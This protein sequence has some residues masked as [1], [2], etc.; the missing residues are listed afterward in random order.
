MAITNITQSNFRYG[1]REY[2]GKTVVDAGATPEA[3]LLANQGDY[4]VDAGTPVT[5]GLEILA[6]VSTAAIDRKCAVATLVAGATT[7]A[8]AI[9][10]PTLVDEDVIVSIGNGKDVRGGQSY[11]LSIT[12]SLYAGALSLRNLYLGSMTPIPVTPVVA[13]G[14][15]TYTAQ[16]APIDTTGNL[17]INWALGFDGKGVGSATI[18]TISLVQVV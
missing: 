17:P 2:P 11:T 12:V 1:G 4:F 18:G 5:A 8:V 3:Y 7:L 15:V 14:V 9:T 13:N 6:D 16:I 10:S